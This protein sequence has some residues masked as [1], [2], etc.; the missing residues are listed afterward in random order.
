MILLLAIIATDLA[1]L[2]ENY[3][4]FS[5]MDVFFLEPFA[6]VDP[7]T[8]W[9]PPP[10]ETESSRLLYGVGYRIL[11]NTTTTVPK[12]N[13]TVKTNSTLLNS[14]AINISNST[15]STDSFV[16]QDYY[17]YRWWIFLG[18]CLNVIIATLIERIFI[19]WFEKKS[20]IKERKD[21]KDKLQR[22]TKD[23]ALQYKTSNE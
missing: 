2:F 18:V 14:T 16:S 7:N 19:T 13:T 15:N 20:D 6:T 21:R 9:V 4:W 10:P 1:I 23:L 3:G 22:L 12:T 8:T 5:Q 17:N 11:A